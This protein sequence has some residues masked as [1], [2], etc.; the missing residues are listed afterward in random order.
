M[1][2]IRI[3]GQPQFFIDDYLVDNRWGVEYLTEAITRV[4]HAPVKH[5]ANPLIAERGGYVN[6]LRAD[7]RFRMWYQEYW[8]QSWTPRKYTYGVAYAE[9]ED[10]LNWQLPRIGRHAFKDTTDNNIV[11]LGP[12]GNRAEVPYLLDVPEKFRR[13]Y[14][15]L[16]LYL[17]DA[18]KSARLIASHDGI[19]WDPASDCCIAAGFT[20]DTHGSIVWDPRLER[21]VW[22]TRATNLYRNRGARRKIARLEHA[23]LWDEWPIRSENILLPDQ[24]DAE[25]HHHYFYGMPT[26]FHAGIYWGFLWPYRHQEDIYTALAFSRNGRDFQRPADRPC[27]IGARR[28]ERMGR[29][30]G[31]GIKLGGGGRRVVDLLRR[32]QRWPQGARPRARHWPRAPAQG[33]FCVAAQPGRRRFRGDQG[34][35]QPRWATLRQCGRDEGRIAGAADRL[36]PRAP[37]QLW[38]PQSTH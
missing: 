7:G 37:A 17:S 5:P 22:F 16:L 29:G 38:R 9:S 13:G 21:L 10:G 30:H 32:H 31:H 25:T 6:V 11:L 4:F 14:E 24:L 33:G 26:R 3:D 27:L 8:D 23:S 2:E 35:A 1:Q 28:A 20:P 36:R 15:Y 34:I 12:G 19:N 18:P